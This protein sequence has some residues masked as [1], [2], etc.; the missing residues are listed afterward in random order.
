MIGMVIEIE[1]LLMVNGGVDRSSTAHRK[2]V[3]P[4]SFDNK[5]NLHLHVCSVHVQFGLIV[6]LVKIYRTII[7]AMPIK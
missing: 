2:V 7:S 4:V 6:V 5:P 1:H 3:L